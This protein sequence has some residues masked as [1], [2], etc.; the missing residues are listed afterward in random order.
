MRY[1]SGARVGIRVC[2][3]GRFGRRLRNVRRIPMVFG[4]DGL[5]VDVLS[6]AIRFGSGLSPTVVT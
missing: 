2:H 1:G 6:R 3:P 5:R 4:A